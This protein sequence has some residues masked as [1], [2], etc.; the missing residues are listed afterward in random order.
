LDID[1]QAS[2]QPLFDKLN[3]WADGAVALLPN[4]AVALLVFVAFYFAGKLANRLAKQVGTRFATNEAVVRLLASVMQY[5]V[6]A[7]GFVVA[8]GVIGLQKAVV[9][10][11]AGAGVAGLAIGFAF[12]D[13]AANFI[14][15]VGMGIRQPFQIGQL[16]KTGEYLGHV[17]TINLR[18][19][20]IR[21]FDGERVIVPNRMVFENPLVNYHAYG[22]RR[23]EVAVGVAYDTD[24]SEA[25]V[26]ARKAIEAL[27]FRAEDTDVQVVAEG[28]GGSSVDFLVRF[29]IPVPDHEYLGARHD[30]IV[31]IKQAFDEKEISIP[32]PVRTLDLT[33]VQASD[34]SLPFRH[35]GHE[36]HAA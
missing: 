2:L 19:T 35:V 21:T 24:L 5:T 22:T 31:A 36:E 8:L 28:F 34:G 15:G 32:F 14:A 12:Q 3:G 18:N 6:L 16:I 4:L 7:L 26:T 10:I 13:L 33:G 9:S 27:D 25:T 20:I 17:E 11:L 23:V 1:I 30:G 29:W